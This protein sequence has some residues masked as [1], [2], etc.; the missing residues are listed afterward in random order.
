M[1]DRLTGAKAYLS[2]VELQ[3]PLG[4]REQIRGTGIDLGRRVEGAGQRVG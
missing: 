4:A 1:A 2:N 3:L